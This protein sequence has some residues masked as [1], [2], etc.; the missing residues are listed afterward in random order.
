ME[1]YT[2]S[3]IEYFTT[4]SNSTS[5][6]IPDTS[7]PNQT[8][9]SVARNTISFKKGGEGDYQYV[10]LYRYSSGKELLL[11]LKLHISL[12]LIIQMDIF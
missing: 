4:N 12:F 7:F 1:F 11:S 6:Y 2:T 9:Y 3:R 10:F 5:W 8:L